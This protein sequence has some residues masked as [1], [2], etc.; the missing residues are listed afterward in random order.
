MKKPESFIFVIF[1]G[2]GDLAKRKLVP[3]LYHL[4]GNNLLPDSFAI[5]GLG[6]KPFNDNSYRQK[7]AE[8]IKTDNYTQGIDNKSLD[9]FIMRIFYSSFDMDN[10]QSYKELRSTLQKLDKD[11]KTNQNFLFYMAIPPEF[12]K[13]VAAGLHAEKLHLELPTGWKRIIVE[14]PFGHDLNSARDLNAHLQ[15]TFDEE[16]IYRID[17]YLGKETVQNI[18]A[19]RFANGIFEPLWNRN[20]ISH[21][22]I[23][24]AENI[25]VE[26]RGGYYDTSGALRDM[27]QNHLLQLAATIAMEPPITF[28]AKAVRDEKY[29][30]FQSM[31]KIDLQQIERQVIRGQYI[32]SMVR[33]QKV[34]GYR[35][36]ENVNPESQ[37]ETF[38]AMK[39]FI[40]NWRWADVPFLIRTGKRLPT[41]VTEVVIHFKKTPYHMFKSFNENHLSENQLILRIQPD[42]GILLKFGMK[43]PG[44]GFRIKNL[45]MD[46]HYSDL[47]DIKIPEAYERLL[48]DALNGNNT[49]FARTDSVEASWQF[50][51]PILNS[52]KIDP[53]IKLYGY[54][55][56]S[57]GPK[58]ARQLFDDPERD[59]R[60]PCKNLTGED[61]YCEL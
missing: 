40:E 6:R 36:E 25:G 32:E 20:Y 35:H 23:T 9:N 61:T 12:F 37:T 1:G 48:L 38:V 52:W 56:G 5:I 3:A 24:S 15:E 19:F 18:L 8:S 7:M 4:Y 28:E 2:S 29:K 57:W 41:R 33:G 16:Q 11:L 51:E 44:T 55:A 60:Y 22:E 34:L 42:E 45:D 49:L 58:E 59:W 10:L 21:L 26:D 43:V 13:K 39:F 53:S 27:V 50:V 17:H 47:A 54:P 31:R 30:F 46:F 14:K